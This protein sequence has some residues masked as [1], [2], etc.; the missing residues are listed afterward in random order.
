LDRLVYCIITELFIF[1]LESVPRKKNS[2]YSYTG[3]I[4]YYYRAGTLVFEGLLGRLTK[5]SVKFLL[6]GYTFP[7]SVRDRLSLARDGNFR[8]RVYF[9]IGSKQDF[10]SLHLRKGALESYNISGSP[11]SVDWLIE[12]QGLGRPFGGADHVKRKR[13]DHNE[14]FPRKRQRI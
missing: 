10:V 11:F 6:R 8:K 12:A 4:L 14:G 3:Y 9:D 2:R 1:E 13:K 7:G 5:S